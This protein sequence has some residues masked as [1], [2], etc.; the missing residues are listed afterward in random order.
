VSLS[1]LAVIVGCFAAVLLVRYY[2]APARRAARVL[3]S[4]PRTRVLQLAPGPVR[5]TGRACK[6]EHAL[7]APVSGR[8]CV[9]YQLT[10]EEAI[11]GQD[12]TVTWRPVLRLADAHPFWVDDGTG[13]VLVEPDAHLEL[14]LDEDRR[15]GSGFLDRVR[16]VDGV[17]R[18]EAFLRMRGV[19]TD[20]WFG[21]RKH[22]YREGV[23]EEGET[24][25][26]GATAVA[27]ES[28]GKLTLRGSEQV[29]IIVTDHPMSDG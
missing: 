25:S 19:V 11:P 24:V 9:A 4:V 8:P 20:G 12:Q 10:I 21:R 2:R 26:V 14:A 29:P 18:L 28:A 27:G 16:D 13:R 1:F 23:V 3:R 6:A 17:A 7:T 5:V 22:R 15:G